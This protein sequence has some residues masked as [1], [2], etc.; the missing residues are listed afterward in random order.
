[1]CQVGVGLVLGWCQISARFEMDAIVTKI[2]R[3]LMF[4]GAC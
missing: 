1:M 3:F 2:Q 4:S